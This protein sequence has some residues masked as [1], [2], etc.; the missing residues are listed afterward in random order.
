[1]SPRSPHRTVLL[2]PVCIRAGFFHSGKAAFEISLARSLL[3]KILE[4]FPHLFPGFSSV[5]SRRPGVPVVRTE[6]SGQRCSQK[7]CQPAD[8]V[9]AA[10]A[11]EGRKSSMK[12]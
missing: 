4:D 2:K 5:P 3:R 10:W 12:G 9:S 1:V 8:E 11:T 6:A 7:W